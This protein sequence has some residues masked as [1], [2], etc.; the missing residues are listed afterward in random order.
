MK[1][2]SNFPLLAIIG[3][4]LSG[5]GMDPDALNAAL[6][7]GL[8]NSAAIQRGEY[9]IGDASGTLAQWHAENDPKDFPEI[10]LDHFCRNGRKPNLHAQQYAWSCAGKTLSGSDRRICEQY[11]DD[12]GCETSD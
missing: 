12:L 1:K 9:P 6:S 2:M 4:T 5:C 8:A 3:A 11:D 7:A 10:D